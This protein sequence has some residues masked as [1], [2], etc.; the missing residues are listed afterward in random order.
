MRRIST[1]V[2]TGLMFVGAAGAADLGVAPE[3]PAPEAS[4]PPALAGLYVGV[5]VG[6]AFEGMNYTNYNDDPVETYDFALDPLVYGLTIGFDTQVTGRWTAGAELRYDYLDAHFAPFSNPGFDTLFT[7]KD[8]TSVVGKVGYLLT[9]GAQLYG[10]L[11]YGSVSVEAPEGADEYK[12]GSQG[13]VVVGVGAET[14]LTDLLS[15]S[16]DARYFRASDEFRTADDVGFK[17]KYLLVTAGLKMRFDQPALTEEG[18][19]DASVY[20]FTGVSLGISADGGVGSMVRDISTAGADTGPF[21]S[22]NVGLGV[23]LGYDIAFGNY[24]AGIEAAVDYQHLP[25]YDAAQD[26]PDP[27]ATTLFATV[28][29]MMALT[30]RLGVQ[31]DPGSIAYAKAGIAGIYTTANADFFALDGGGESMLPGYQLGVG[32]ESFVSDQLSLSAEGLYT[33]AT[34]ALVTENTQ[35]EQVRLFPR[36]LTAKVGLKY[37]M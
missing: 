17:S 18:A 3:A 12:S 5:N 30:A 6:D 34:D 25:F 35:S 37:R 8:S 11:G 19:V 14:R 26:S 27:D 7:M 2:V 24:V 10:V 22:E 31:L 4:V 20:D 29:G 1:A 16:V 33:E 9:P 32:V 13:G 23:N 15:A 36:L 21:W 28:E